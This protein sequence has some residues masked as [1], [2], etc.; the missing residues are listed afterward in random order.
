MLC[1]STSRGDYIHHLQN[2]SWVERNRHLFA[3]HHLHKFGSGWLRTYQAVRPSYAALGCRLTIGTI[4]REPV[5]LFRSWY[6]HFGGGRPMTIL[7]AQQSDML[8]WS[9]GGGQGINLSATEVVGRVLRLARVAVRGLD[10][11]GL[12]ERWDESIVL[13]LDALGL[14]LPPVSPHISTAAPLAADAAS[15]AHEALLRRLNAV[16]IEYYRDATALFEERVLAR[17]RS[18]SRF[19]SRVIAFRRLPR[20]HTLYGGFSGA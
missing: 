11:I 20:T 15:G 4:L 9:W 13:L 18:D 6:R 3:E 19:E 10:W 2:R 12:N 5:S 17:Q 1:A 7:A 14:P 16:S 8:L